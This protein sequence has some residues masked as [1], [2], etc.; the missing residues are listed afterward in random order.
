MPRNPTPMN[1][2]AQPAVG[3]R[4]PKS[5]DSRSAVGYLRVSTDLQ[6]ESGL[7]LDAQRDQILAYAKSKGLT[8]TGFYS[9]TKSGTAGLDSRNGLSALIADLAPNQVVLVA[10]R[11][12]LARDL[13]LSLWIEKEVAKVQCSV[14]SCDGSGNGSTPTDILLKNMIL[15]FGEFERSMI[16]ERTR[17]AM[18]SLAK[19]RKLGR[20]RF[21]F[22]YTNEGQLVPDPGT[23]QHYLAIVA[24]HRE[25]MNPNQIA[26]RLN[27]LGIRSQ[28]G[29]QF[30]R[31]VVVQ[32]VLKAAD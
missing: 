10:K 8:V 27:E 22:R 15:A 13:M 9:D 17:V 20:P 28:T 3:P 6:E 4:L 29:K 19:T 31:N 7:G 14:E 12:R 24:M 25:G 23:H 2:T 1:P 16:A 11:D 32:I 5:R 21:G 26:K 18:R 30:S